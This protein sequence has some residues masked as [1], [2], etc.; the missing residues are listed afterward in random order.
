M[1]TDIKQVSSSKCFGGQQKVF[2]HQSKELSCRMKFSIFLP[3]TADM[4][5]ATKLP[6]VYFLSGL[7]CTE[8]NF[9]TKS[10]FQRYAEELK[11]IVVGPDTSPRDCNVAGENDSWDLGTGAGFYVDATQ[12]PWN[13]HYRMYSYVT[14]ELRDV[15][16]KNFPCVDGTRIGITGHSMGGHGALV[17]FLRNPQVYKAVSAFAP[18]SNSTGSSWGQKCMSAYLGPDQTTW[19]EY[20]ATEL[21]MRQPQ[22]SVNILVEQGANDEWMS[23]LVPNNFVKA[24][25]SIGQPIT[26]NEREGYD[27]G[28]YF[29]STFIYDHLKHFAEALRR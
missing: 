15:V 20:D 22:K 14:K 28:Y 1:A 13:K 12:A 4:T 26:Y 29:V 3:S 17:C 27:H 8:Q 19:K 23:Y 10:G 2:E 5:G 25:Q 16:E 9:I 24:C 21:V 7:T 6:T 11:L 18:I